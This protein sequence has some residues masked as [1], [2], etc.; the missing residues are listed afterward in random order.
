MALL[1]LRDIEVFFNNLKKLYWSKQISFFVVDNSLEVLVDIDNFGI[2]ES[3]KQTISDYHEHYMNYLQYNKD[4]K[5]RYT[6]INDDYFFIYRPVFNENEIIGG[7]FLVIQSNDLNKDFK[8]NI[9]TYYDKIKTIEK[10][11]EAELISYGKYKC[12]ASKMSYFSKA[13]NFVNVGLIVIDINMKIKFVNDVVEEKLELK[14]EDILMASIG[15]IFKDI[16]ITDFFNGKQYKLVKKVLCMKNKQL[17]DLILFCADDCEKV[18]NIGIIIEDIHKVQNSD[19]NFQ[20]SPIRFQDIIGEDENFIKVKEFAKKIA[21]KDADILIL[22]ES[23]TGKE[24]FARAIH[25]SSSRRKGPF[26]AIN[27]SAIPNELL[28]S[29]LFG[30][31]GGAFT[32]ASKGGKPGKFELANGGIIFLDEIGDMSYYLQAKML[33]VVQERVFERVGGTK[34]ISVDVRII[35]ATNKNLKKMVN[36]GSFREDLY[37]RL[38]VIPLLLPAVR[39][40]KKDVKILIDHYFEKYSS[41]YGNEIYKVEEKA[42]ELLVTYD[43]PGNVR[44]LENT[45]QFLCCVNTDGVVSESLVKRRINF[46]NKKD[47]ATS[48][49]NKGI[50]TLKELEIKAIKDV[51]S[52]YGESAEGKEQAA[53]AL[54]IGLS[55]LYKKL[56]E[57]KIKVYTP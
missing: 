40:R 4:N 29:E 18:E 5:D 28:E 22:G 35:A 39:D 42:M 36:E 6:K 23:G 32:G 37:Y 3:I 8:K 57:Y 38:N 33:R 19:I 54:G 47:N 52:I 24:I 51:L 16:E 17:Y 14:N 53:R 27:C 49:V 48:V 12:L 44:E 43:W 1:K 11:I 10:M 34:S 31:Q 30:Y 25:N 9:D 13:L 45:I 55:T 26:I 46:M 2:N 41:I 21:L 7:V 15:S 50:V 20:Y 56:K